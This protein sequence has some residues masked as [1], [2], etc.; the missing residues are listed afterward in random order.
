MRKLVGTVGIEDNDE[1]NFKDLQGV[2]RNAKSLKRNQRARKGILIAPSEL[3]RFSSG[4]EIL[5]ILLAGNIGFG[6]KIRGTDGEP[7]LHLDN[8]H[9]LES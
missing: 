7:T 4:V 2:Q 8:L 9:T 6:P 1:W 5:P 3:P